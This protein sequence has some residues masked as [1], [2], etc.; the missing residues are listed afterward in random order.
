M[1]NVRGVR[2]PAWSDFIVVS[3]LCYY[4]LLFFEQLKSVKTEE[5]LRAIP[6]EVMDVIEESG[7][8]KQLK[9]E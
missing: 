4:P 1:R 6:D 9:V 3:L 8:D 5:D 7:C 2:E